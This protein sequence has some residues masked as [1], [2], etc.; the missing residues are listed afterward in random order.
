[1]VSSTLTFPSSVEDPTKE[2]MPPL[3]SPSISLIPAAECELI[4]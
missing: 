2:G 3:S 4:E 1:M